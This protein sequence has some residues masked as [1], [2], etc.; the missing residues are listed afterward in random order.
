MLSS[1]ADDVDSTSVI[2]ECAA[3]LWNLSLDGSHG[4]A[5]SGLKTFCVCF[6]GWLDRKWLC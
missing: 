1:L 2:I 3:R 5:D 4:L 6:F